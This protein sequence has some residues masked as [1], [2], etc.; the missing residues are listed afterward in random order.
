MLRRGVTLRRPTGGRRSP[1]ASRWRIRHK[2]LLGLGLVVATMALLLSGTSRGLLSNYRTVNGIKTRLAELNAAE[3]LKGLVFDLAAPED[4]SKLVKEQLQLPKAIRKVRDAIETYEQRLD[5]TLAANRDPLRGIYEK[6]QIEL[7]LK[8]LD[9][10]QQ[11]V[12]RRASAAISSTG[13][14]N[15][16]KEQDEAAL[17]PVMT[18]LRT[19][20]IDLRD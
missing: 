1:V 6:S 15:E 9:V 5:E 11:A 17:R 12:V 13:N 2:L 20:V 3:E 16:L 18:A 8:D 19:D 4:A 14:D 7:L 10:F